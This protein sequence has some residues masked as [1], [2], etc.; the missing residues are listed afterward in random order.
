MVRTYSF[1]VG[2]V[3]EQLDRIL[4]MEL[5]GIVLHALLLYGLRSRAD[6]DHLLAAR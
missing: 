5:A 3:V 4:Q 6:S 2:P 1:E